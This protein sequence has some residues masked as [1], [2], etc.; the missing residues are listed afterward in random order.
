MKNLWKVTLWAIALLSMLL[1]LWGCGE[2]EHTC[3]GETWVTEKEATCTVEGSKK[4]V[5]SCGKTVRTE[6]IPLF[7]H[8]EVTV[9]GR[10][11]TCTQKGWV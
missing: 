5:C 3:V 4:F 2:D 11:S 7:S 6:K 9:S 10:A 8:T 1:V